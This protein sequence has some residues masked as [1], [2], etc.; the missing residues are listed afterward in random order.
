[1][2]VS[3]FTAAINQ[4]CDEK[5]LKEEEVISAVES[6]VAAAYRKDYGH[7]KEMVRA[8]Y[9]TKT[10]RFKIFQEFEVV[11][12]KELK[13]RAKEEAKERGKDPKEIEEIEVKPDPHTQLIL[14]QA[15]KIDKKA[16]LGK[17]VKK[18]LPYKDD[19][20]RIA[21]MTAKQVIVQRLREAEKNMLYDEYKKKENEV[22]PAVVQQIEGKNI[23]V[24]I[25][26]TNALLPPS[27]QIAKEHYYIGQR[28]RVFVK[29]VDQASRG[30]RI[31]V[32]RAHPGLLD[33]LFRLEV[34]EIN[35]KTV[36]IK[37]IARE[38]G[39]RSKV[40]ISTLDKQLDPVGT[41]VGQRG[42]R[43]QAILAEIGDEKIDIIVWDKDPKKFLINALAP[44][45]I[46]KVTLTRDKKNA[47]VKVA[48]DQLSL[49]IGKNGQ[50][51]RLASKLTGI[52]VDIVKPPLKVKS[53]VKADA[54]K[55]KAKETTKAQTAKAKKKP[56]QSE[57]KSATNPPTSK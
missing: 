33:G 30:P 25:G 44:A 9:D 7:P 51:V 16:K 24:N 41:C 43:I 36:E 31:L 45:E 42:A 54:K 53:A 15:K 13:K 40:A 50:N 5:G 34:P 56:S 46:E 11:D 52:E 17:T 14:S 2:P 8:K 37:A 19:F 20:G 39:A 26:K 57:E 49:A 4:I 6:A 10:G 28:M 29:E 38:P 3:S 47:K 55:E 32:S 1:M 35:A 12:E 22:I 21:A 27:E 48:E 18:D 23:I